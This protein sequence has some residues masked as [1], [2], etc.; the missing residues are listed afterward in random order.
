[1][2]M[3]LKIW[4]LIMGMIMAFFSAKTPAKAYKPET[5]VINGITYK[6]CFIPEY[7]GL[8]IRNDDD[9]KKRYFD[10]NDPFYTA[11]SG[12]FR[13]KTKWYKINEKIIICGSDEYPSSPLSGAPGTIYYCRESDWNDLKAYYGNMNNWTCYIGDIYHT[14][15]SKH[16]EIEEEYFNA[17]LWKKIMQ[18]DYDCD[19][20]DMY[21]PVELPI[22]QND[23][24]DYTF[25]HLNMYMKSSDE[26]FYAHVSDILQYKGDIYIQKVYY[27]GFYVKAYK[28]PSELQEYILKLTK[29]YDSAVHF[30][31]Q[32]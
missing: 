20:T 11:E 28:F 8:N 27:E 7:A 13:S 24:K 30:V 21:K 25:V 19:E 16:I 31:K 22:N 9:S 14:E 5:V 26:V 18:F 12:L 15:D 4:A 10:I 23:I 29:Q 17:D 6:N 32:S 1:M 2:G 3:F